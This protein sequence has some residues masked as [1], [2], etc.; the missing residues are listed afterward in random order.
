MEERPLCQL[1]LSNP[2]LKSQ[3]ISHLKRTVTQIP[4]ST[5][6]IRKHHRYQPDWFI[7]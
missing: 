1:V 2:R 3:H 5:R 6:T 7:L 4:P